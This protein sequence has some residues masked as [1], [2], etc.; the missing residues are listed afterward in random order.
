[1]LPLKRLWERA[2]NPEGSRHSSDGRTKHMVS[3]DAA[4]GVDLPRE[5]SP[6]QQQG[7]DWVALISSGRATAD[8]VAAM[9]RW[10]MENPT[11]AEALAL[12]LRMRKFSH[13]QPTPASEH[14][15]P[16]LLERPMTRRTIMAGGALAVVGYGALQPPLALWP[17]LSELSSDYRT[18]VGERRQVGLA[19]G[20]SLDLNTHTSISLRSAPGRTGIH[21]SEGEIAVSAKLPSSQ[22]F[23][24]YVSSGT[25]SAQQADFDVR[26]TDDGFRATC[27][28][29]TLQVVCNQKRVELGAGEAVLSSNDALGRTTQ[30]DA[31]VVSGWRRGKLIFYDASLSSIVAEIN[32]YRPGRIVITSSDLAAR[33]FSASFQIART[34]GIVDDIQRLAGASAV[35]LPGGVVFLS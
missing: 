6:I 14:F 32:R 12:A 34:S 33:R 1:M 28:E 10:Q 4:A 9:K 18:A 25:V 29:G 35:R 11:H 30:V 13:L 17:S 20:L 26:T 3:L 8:D 15:P 7:L 2:L 23:V 24:A 22:L 21:L 5:L 19:N 16:S 31:S 27:L